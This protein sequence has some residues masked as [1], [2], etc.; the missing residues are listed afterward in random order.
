MQASVTFQKGRRVAYLPQKVLD[1]SQRWMKDGMVMIDVEDTSKRYQEIRK[2]KKS[3]NLNA[4]ITLTFVDHLTSSPDPQYENHFP[5]SRPP[6]KSIAHI[7]LPA[8]PHHHP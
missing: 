5:Y 2:S 4:I 1:D 7:S 8:H 3:K 6:I